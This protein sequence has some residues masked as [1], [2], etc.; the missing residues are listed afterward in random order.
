MLIYRNPDSYQGEDKDKCYL[1]NFF[2]FFSVLL[3]NVKLFSYQQF[4]INKRSQYPAQESYT[5]LEKSYMILGSTAY[6][7]SS[8]FRLFPCIFLKTEGL[9]PMVFLN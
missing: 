8:G 4:Y 7:L 3:T 2:Q 9:N 1:E 6:T 5:I